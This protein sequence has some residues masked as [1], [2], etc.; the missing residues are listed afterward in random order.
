MPRQSLSTLRPL[1]SPATPERA[2]PDR[3]RGPG[4]GS[5]PPSSTPGNAH[6]PPRRGNEGSPLRTAGMGPP[7]LPPRLGLNNLPLPGDRRRGLPARPHTAELPIIGP[8]LDEWARKAK[9]EAPP[10]PRVTGIAAPVF[11]ETRDKSIDAAHAA[12]RKAA[13]SGAT[14]LQIENLQA[15]RLP[16]AALSELPGLEHLVLKGTLCRKL[17]DFTPNLARLGTL[18]LHGNVELERLPEN[19]RMLQAL[20][21]LDIRNSLLLRSL[22]TGIG[23]LPQ[24]ATLNLIGTSIR[25]L[26]PTFANLSHSLRTLE[27]STPPSPRTDN[28]LLK[29]PDNIGDFQ[30][31]T[32]LKLHRQEGLTELPASLGNLSKL[33]TLDLSHCINLTS[34]PDLSRLSSL[35]TLDLSGCSQLSPLPASLAGLPADCRIIVTNR[36][37][38]KELDAL[39]PRR[40]QRQPAS[41]GTASGSRFQPQAPAEA[42]T[43]Q[44]KLKGWTEQLKPFKA[45]GER[46][47]DRFNIL[48]D[49]MVRQPG[50]D[51]A[52][53]GKI[54]AVVKAAVASPDFRAKLFAFAAENVQVPRSSL[55]RRQTD[56]ATVRSKDVND[57]HELLVMHQVSD[58]RTN[59]RQANDTLL[60]VAMEQPAFSRGLLQL[61]VDKP[62]S[63]PAQVPALL[64]AYVQTHDPDGKAIMEARR[65][66]T[67]RRGRSSGSGEAAAQAVAIANNDALLHARHVAV[68]KQLVAAI[69]PNLPPP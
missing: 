56:R 62:G 3:A 19:I 25:E 42:A 55:G 14:S 40:T 10:R 66:L 31:L 43:R 6:L 18:E 37:Q 35:K 50:Q 22:P 41:A 53:I 20:T 54:D 5:S 29:L 36:Q 52:D 26:P 30:S 17:P 33:E 32:A 8:H 34:L 11:S 51:S 1:Q 60:Q 57:V 15:T 68:A 46:G 49:A 9:A 69:H 27:I 65:N 2:L 63:R 13:E 23:S 38:Q 47:A 28:G 44:Q 67:D 24:L 16:S 7:A 21:T 61:A 59:A 64:A 48:M 45:K 12:V 39:R 4:I 58:P